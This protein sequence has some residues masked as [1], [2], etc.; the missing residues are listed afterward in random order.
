LD[1]G[2]DEGNLLL[3]NGRPMEK[4]T[5]HQLDQGRSALAA[6]I[7]DMNPDG[8]AT[9]DATT[10]RM[11]MY[12]YADLHTV[13]NVYSRAYTR[14]T[15]RISHL[16]RCQFIEG[17]VLVTYIA[18][19]HFFVLAESPDGNPANCI[20]LAVC[21]LYT[22]QQVQ[23]SVGTAWTAKYP[24][25]PAHRH[26]GVRLSEMSEKMVMCTCEEVGHTQ[27]ME[28]GSTSGSGRFGKGSHVNGADDNVDDAM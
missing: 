20:R 22:L 4:W 25:S 6:C 7:Q 2:D 11:T 13:Q 14:A 23:R 27:F 28:Y 26:H 16:V 17:D 12:Q 24:A 19:V 3:G 18:D 15:R 1:I 8:W 10:A 21:D 5:Q 9:Q